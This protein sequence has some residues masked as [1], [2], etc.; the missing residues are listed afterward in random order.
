MI[1]NRTFHQSPLFPQGYSK[2][3]MIKGALHLTLSLEVNARQTISIHLNYLL[4]C[5]I[6]Q[7][8]TVAKI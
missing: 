1:V 4:M 2:S 7:G 6:K 5:S 3:G 8:D